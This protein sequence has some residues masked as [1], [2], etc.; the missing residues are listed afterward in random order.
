MKK[1]HFFNYFLHH[2]FYSNL[3]TLEQLLLNFNALTSIDANAFNGLTSL[4]SLSLSSTSISELNPAWFSTLSSLRTFAATNN[5]IR[6]LPDN[7]FSALGS[8]VDLFLYG[9]RIRDITFAAFGTLGTSNLH[10][11]YL[12]DNLVNNIDIEWLVNANSLEYL[13]LADNLCI[14]QDFLN[15]QNI[16]WR[17]FEQLMRCTENFAMEPQLSCHYNELMDGGYACSLFIHNPNAFDEFEAIDGDHLAGRNNEDVTTL[18]AFYQ[19]T[20]IIPS[21]LCATFPNL[22]VVFV[23]QSNLEDLR[24]ASFAD[25]ANLEVLYLHDNWINAVPDFTFRNNPNLRQLELGMNWIETLSENSFAGSAIENLDI[26]ANRLSELR[27]EWF[28]P[29][30]E[31]LVTLDAVGNIIGTLGDDAFS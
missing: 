15:V 18:T 17:I 13:L 12:S 5:Q 6:E 31:T 27:Q 3:A 30:N 24:E 7:V 21:I 28:G 23:M 22:Q 20:R 2:F 14:D 8:L 19:N 4:E 10:T 16:Q 29:I 9:N 11:V 25:C 1:I 26:D